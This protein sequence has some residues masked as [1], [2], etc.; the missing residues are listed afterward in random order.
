MNEVKK[1]PSAQALK[2]DDFFSIST[3]SGYRRMRRDPQGKSHLLPPDAS[4][5]AIGSAVLDALAHTRLIKLEEAAE[6][7]D[8]ELCKQQGAQWVDAMVQ[9]YG[10]KSRRAL[11]KDMQCCGI[12]STEGLITISPMRH[13]TLERFG[14][15]KGDGIVEVKVSADSTPQQIGAALRLGFSR[16][17]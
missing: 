7:F 6:F 2:N 5:E 3:L 1:R 13:E 4:D 16:C 9:R 15:E 12:E 10:Y 11:F 17:I 14:R 8:Y